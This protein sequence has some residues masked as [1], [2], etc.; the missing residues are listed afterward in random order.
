MVSAYADLNSARRKLGFALLP[1]L[2]EAL[3]K[4]VQPLQDVLD[5]AEAINQFVDFNE[6]YYA[7]M[8]AVVK[9]FGGSRHSIA[10]GTNYTPDGERRPVSAVALQWKEALAEAGKKM[11]DLLPISETCRRAIENRKEKAAEER[12][13][14][15]RQKPSYV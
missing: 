15:E 6:Y 14:Q 13:R 3:D 11:S 2:N 1:I 9:C 12:M 4:A 10:L 5:V 8:E 7:R